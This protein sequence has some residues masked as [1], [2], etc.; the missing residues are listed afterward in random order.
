MTPPQ[1]SKREALRLSV[2][3]NMLVSGATIY[4]WPMRM[5]Q[6]RFDVS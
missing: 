3:L 2:Q 1:I 4:A 6:T 5:R